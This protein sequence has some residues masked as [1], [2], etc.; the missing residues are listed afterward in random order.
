MVAGLIKGRH[1]LPSEV[2]EYI[3]EDYTIGDVTDVVA[4]ENHARRWIER[5]NPKEL[6]VFVTGLTVALV[7]VINA[8]REEHIPLF[9]MHYNRET[10]QYFHQTVK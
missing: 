1:N 9:L 4:I 10:R 3:W 5:H 7:A 2:Q 8:C 6:T